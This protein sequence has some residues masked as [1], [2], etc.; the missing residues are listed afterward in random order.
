VRS[1]A[2]SPDGKLLAS[3]GRDGT[4]NLW[5]VASGKVL[6]TTQEGVLGFQAVAF[7]T[8]GKS[9]ATGGI[10]CNVSLWDVAEVLKR[11]PSK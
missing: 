4:L 6:A 3:A 5:D 2:L 11:K 10:D 7:S 8:D 1:L 9:L